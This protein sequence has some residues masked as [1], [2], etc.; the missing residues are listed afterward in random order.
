MRKTHYHQRS[1]TE[2]WRLLCT[3]DRNQDGR[4]VKYR[5]KITANLEICIRQKCLSKV[6]VE[7]REDRCFQTGQKRSLRDCHQQTHAERLA[8]MFPC[9]E[10]KIFPSGSTGKEKRMKST[11]E[12]NKVW[13]AADCKTAGNSAGQQHR[14]LETKQPSSA[15][16]SLWVTKQPS[17]YWV[18]ERIAL[19]CPRIGISSSPS[20]WTVGSWSPVS[21]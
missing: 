16:R 18:S 19:W 20:S 12:A 8:K 10:E 15:V 2:D 11:G 14:A 3:A 17:L 1:N 6:K 9:I 5:E 21:P 4:T 13:S 7:D